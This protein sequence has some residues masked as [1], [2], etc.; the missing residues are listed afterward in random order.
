MEL[1]IW[2]SIERQESPPHLTSQ[3]EA[4]LIDLLLAV[5]IIGGRYVEVL[6]LVGSLPA[7]LAVGSDYQSEEDC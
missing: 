2:N 5:I 6:L 7:E 3:I 1:D 4:P